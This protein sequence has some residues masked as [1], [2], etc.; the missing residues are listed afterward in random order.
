MIECKNIS[1]AY[2]GQKRLFDGLNVSFLP[3]RV[4]VILGPNGC[5]KSTLL[6]LS[7]RLLKPDGG[8]IL[9][10]GVNVQTMKRKALAKRITLLEQSHTLPAIT[11]KDLVS[12]GRYPYQNWRKGMDEEDRRCV[13]E[14]M[15]MTDTVQF[16]DKDLHHLSGGQCQRVYLAMALAQNTDLLLL[17]EPTSALDIHVCFEI[18]D[19]VSGLKQAGKTVVMVLHD[20]SLALQY[21]DH[22]LLLQEGR[23]VASGT[24]DQLIRDGS[25]DRVFDVQTHTLSLAHQKVYAFSGR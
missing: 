14:A 12:Y 22:I 23:F 24:P 3:H 11:V 17:D 2:P 6:K 7:N 10:D 8:E 9:L 1:F 5:G 18:M 16:R 25:L 19:L 4:T 15:R 20:L 13:D 21:A